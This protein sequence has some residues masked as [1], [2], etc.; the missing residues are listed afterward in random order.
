M[1]CGDRS[2]DQFSREFDFITRLHADEFARQ[3]SPIETLE[4]LQHVI[5]RID[6]IFGQIDC[7]G[8]HFHHATTGDVD[9][10]C[11]DV[12]E[13]CVRD[14]PGVGSHEGPRLRTEIEPQF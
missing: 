12:V 8:R 7:G 14:E 4:C 9:G 3:A 13:M 1:F 2:D 6:R 10:Q 11:C 5:N